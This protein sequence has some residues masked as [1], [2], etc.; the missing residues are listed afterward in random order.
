MDKLISLVA[1][2]QNIYSRWIFRRLLYGMIAV[3]T[4]AIITAMMVS[5]IL[6]GILYAFYQVLL[7]LGVA[8][9][10]ATLCVTGLVTVMVLLFIYTTTLLLHRLREMPRQLLQKK[11]PDISEAGDVIDAFFSG[12]LETP[13]K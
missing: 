11:M 4:L 13:T 5:A 3:A 9:L 7:N 10:P 8:P 2:A 12:F 1:I 6:I